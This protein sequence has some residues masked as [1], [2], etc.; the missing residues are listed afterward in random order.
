MWE[1]KIMLLRLKFEDFYK[2]YG[3]KRHTLLAVLNI[4]EIYFSESDYNS[5]Y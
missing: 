1:S 4:D 3:I 5:L 2:C